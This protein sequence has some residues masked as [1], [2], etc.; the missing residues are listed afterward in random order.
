M[1]V[2]VK[3]VPGAAAGGRVI[4]VADG[5]LSPMAGHCHRGAKRGAGV[6]SAILSPVRLDL[7]S[8]VFEPPA[9]RSRTADHLAGLSKP[10]WTPMEPA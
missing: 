7:Q 8:D 10:A 9:I 1:P 6:A 5:M 4:H 3:P 2:H